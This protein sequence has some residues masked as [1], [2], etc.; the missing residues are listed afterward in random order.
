MAHSIFKLAGAILACFTLLAG[1]GPRH[2]APTSEDLSSIEKCCQFATSCSA[3][4]DW[5]TFYDILHPDIQRQLT[6]KQFILGIKLHGKFSRLIRKAEFQSAVAAGERGTAR[7]IAH[8]GGPPRR[9]D[10]RSHAYGVWPRPALDLGGRRV[11]SQDFDAWP[12]TP[13]LVA[14]RANTRDQTSRAR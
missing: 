9:E 11:E 2:P 10:P 4:S 3:V 6:R 1:C 7:I 5:G 13:R 14:V 12:P 8:A